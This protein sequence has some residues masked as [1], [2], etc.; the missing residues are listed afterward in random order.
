MI[1]F[2][3]LL[4]YVKQAQFKENKLTGKITVVTMV[5]MLKNLQNS[6]S[7]WH[8]KTLSTEISVFPV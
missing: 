6:D 8:C 3:F 5:T 4:L 1:S 7:Y 2:K